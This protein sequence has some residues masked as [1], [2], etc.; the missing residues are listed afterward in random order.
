MLGDIKMMQLRE[1]R[2][3]NSCGVQTVR[4]YMARSEAAG[5]D[6]RHMWDG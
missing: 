4:G 2:E 5:P 6:K 1:E 3:E